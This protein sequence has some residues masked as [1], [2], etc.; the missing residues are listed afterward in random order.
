LIIS[1]TAT[2]SKIWKKKKKERKYKK[3]YRT[4]NIEKG[5]DKKEEMGQ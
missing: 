1:G 4:R 5:V 3:T 2:Y